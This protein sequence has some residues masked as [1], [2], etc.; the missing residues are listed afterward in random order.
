MVKS[1]REE[2]K[3]MELW[4]H[5]AEL[6]SRLIRGALYVLA[7][8]IIAW[9]AYPWIYQLFFAPMR[10]V[11]DAHPDWRPVFRDITEGF[12]VRL[13]VALF[14]GLALAVP[15]ITLE[16][17]GFIAPGLTRSERK[18]FYLVVPLSLLFFFMGILCGYVVMYPSVQWFSN[19]IPADAQL[20]QSPLTYIVFM[21]KMVL[22]FGICFQLPLVLMFLS[23]VGMVTS[24]ALKQHW[25]VAVVLCFAVGAIATPGGDPFSMA[26]MAAPL[27][28]LF[29]ASISLVAFVE[30]VK[31]RQEK[32]AAAAE[33]ERS[34]RQP[35]TVTAGD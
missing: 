13:Q 24:T 10:P 5:L 12:M 32:K 6:R 1:E 27:A 3:E 23:Y 25:R 7:G 31:L 22:A 29:L 21:V 20:L 4:E 11:F 2:F 14:S 28:I 35:S 18:A 19:F 17:W 34:S 16:A 30:R 9:I 8:L 15:G 33:R 26:L